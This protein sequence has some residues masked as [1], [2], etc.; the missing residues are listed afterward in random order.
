MAR[1]SVVVPTYNRA[2][3][4]CAA[5][6]GAR[7]QTVSELQIIVVDDGSTDG[8]RERVG[9]TGDVV[10]TE[11][12]HS[13]LPGVARNAGIRHATG[14]Y[15]AFLDSDDRWLPGKLERQTAILD[16][17]PGVGLVWSNAA[18]GAAERPLYL[19]ADLPGGTV[20]F[21]ALLKENRVIASTA[22]IR[23]S[24]LDRC[25]R[26]SEDRA[27]RGCEDYDLWLRAA[28]LSDV[29]Y[30]P[31]PLA[32]YRDEPG[33]SIRGSQSR[34]DHL[35]AVMLALER[36]TRFAIANAAADADVRAAHRRW[37]THRRRLVGAL[38][39]EGRNVD[40][41]RVGAGSALPSLLFHAR[42]RATRRRRRRARGEIAVL[43]APGGSHRGMR[44]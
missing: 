35:R 33:D 32:V 16:R 7:T 40:A 17:N 9:A 29:W 25:G 11:L 26:F 23:R 34:A 15:V 12:R 38:L 30:E 39:A 20:S 1:I 6:E 8:T 22:M 31:A 27:L 21:R 42:S 5:I 41:I 18:V 10:Y 19:A 37:L 14:E 43:P 36:A 28:V 24:L 4:V 3:L 2:R 44:Q 13:G